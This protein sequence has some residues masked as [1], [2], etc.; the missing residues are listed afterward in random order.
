MV[1]YYEAMTQMIP[2]RQALEEAN[3]KLQNATEKLRKVK[4]EV[5]TL[6]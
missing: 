2:K 6:E 4:E 5:F 3:Q 1:E